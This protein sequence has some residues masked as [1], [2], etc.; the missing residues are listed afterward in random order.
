M[1][2]NKLVALLEN[3]LKDRLQEA[4]LSS[5]EGRLTTARKGAKAS[6]GGYSGWVKLSGKTWKNK[7]TGKMMHSQALASHIGGFNDFKIV[8][9]A[10]S[11]GGYQTAEKRLASAKRGAKASGGGYSG[12]VKTGR[13]SWKNKKTGRNAHSQALASQLGGFSDFKI[14]EGVVNEDES[15][16]YVVTYQDKAFNKT[17]TAQI[18]PGIS[19]ADIVKMLKKTIRVGLK[20]ISI[21]SLK[22]SVKEAYTSERDPKAANR[23]KVI[24]KGGRKLKAKKDSVTYDQAM[25]TK[26]IESKILKHVQQKHNVM[27]SARSLANNRGRSEKNIETL[28]KLAKKTGDRQLSGL[29]DTWVITAYD[30]NLIESDA[31]YA[32]SLEKIAKDRQLK[33]L[34]KKDKETLLKIAKLM[35]TANESNL[36]ESITEADIKQFEKKLDAMVVKYVKDNLKLDPD[37]EG[38]AFVDLKKLIKTYSFSKVRNLR[39]R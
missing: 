35:K 13:N 10:V 27:Q 1:D 11:E 4:S 3:K 31:E 18:P 14:K 23:N 22:E 15:K 12:W 29:I 24:A 38:K 8:G 28:Y 5:I 16:G 25:S 26:D 32:K 9:E 21:D 30:N 6:G 39:G 17:Y 20:I 2:K 19:K 33:M 37:E 34:S 36:G 7:K